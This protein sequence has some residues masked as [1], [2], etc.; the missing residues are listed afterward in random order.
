MHICYFKKKYFFRLNQVNLYN[1]EPNFLVE[2]TRMRL[3]NYAHWQVIAQ[4]CR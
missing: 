4:G 3:N 2:S 1:P